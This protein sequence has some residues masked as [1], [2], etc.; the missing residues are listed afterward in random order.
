MLP[1]PK[2]T[3][4]D[5]EH[6]DARNRVFWL[7]PAPASTILALGGSGCYTV[8]RFSRM[9]TI[10][11]TEIPGGWASLEGGVSYNALSLAITV[12]GTFLTLLGVVIAVSQIRK[13]RVAAEAARQ[14]AMDT[15]ARLLKLGAVVDFTRLYS[16][17]NETLVRLHKQDFGGAAIR[18]A[19]LRA[20][21]VELRA[22]PKGKGVQSAKK[23]QGLVTELKGLQEVLEE[24]NSGKDQDG[25]LARRLK[26]QMAEIHDKM[27]ALAASTE[28]SVGET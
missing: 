13:T 25:N 1:L 21:V 7:P 23:W 8:R 14:A 5:T 4:R 22:S 3:A 20:K 26:R 19:D 24:Y 6:S 17:S 18:V 27:N 12:G 11:Q 15:A 10:A 16:L 2:A 28:R 9:I